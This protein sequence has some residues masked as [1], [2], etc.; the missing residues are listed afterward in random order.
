MLIEAEI[1]FGWYPDWGGLT[2]VEEFLTA[3]KNH[4][5]QYG[6]RIVDSYD[7]HYPDSDDSHWPTLTDVEKLRATVDQTYPGKL[8]FFKKMI[9]LF[10]EREYLSANGT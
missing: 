8:I 1:Q 3:L 4:D 6:T 9:N 7:C 5:T 2:Y 10:E